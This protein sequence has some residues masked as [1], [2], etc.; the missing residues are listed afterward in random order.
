[1]CYNV[2]FNKVFRDVER[3][4]AKA[5]NHNK[6]LPEAIQQTKLNVDTLTEPLKRMGWADLELYE[7]TKYLGPVKR[8]PHE[9][10]GRPLRTEHG[11]LSSVGKKK[12]KG[13]I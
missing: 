4:A 7:R 13:V 8:F 3:M 1:M 12:S 11:K 10:T 6:R 9:F 2:V 5:K